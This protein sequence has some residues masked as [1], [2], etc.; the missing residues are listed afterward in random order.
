[1]IRSAIF[2]ILVLS[3]TA[4][5]GQPDK[6]WTW[7]FWPGSAVTEQGITD[8]LLSFKKSGFGGV[9][10]NAIYAARDAQHPPIPYM[11]N[12]W[13]EKI[14]Y[15]LKVADSLGMQADLSLVSGWPFGGPTVQPADAAKKLA[16]ISLGV[17][18]GG[19]RIEKKIFSPDTATLLALTACRSGGKP[20]QLLNQVDNHGVLYAR[21]PAG[22]WKLYG[23]YLKP[24]GQMVKRAGPGG[25]GRVMDPFNRQAVERYLSGFDQAA[26]TYS[27][28]KLRALFNDSYE[29][30]GA[31]GTP[32]ILKEFRIRR[33]YALEDYP[34][35]FLGPDSNP[36][37]LRILADY[38]ETIAELLLENFLQPWNEWC[39]AHGLLTRE[40][41]HG[42]PGNLL[43]LYAA[44]DIPE[45]ESFGSGAFDIPLVR[46][47]PDFSPATFGRPDPLV[48]KFASSAANLSGKK[49]VSAE[50]ATWLAN[51]FKVSLSQV[52]PQLD[53]L[54]AAGINQVMLASAAYSPPGV[55][56][57][58]WLFYAST[59]FGASSAFYS[60]LPDFSRYISTCQQL[61]QK[62]PT[63]NDLLL[64]FP[65]H[66]IISTIGKD[67]GNLV[68][69]DVH[70]PE[71][72]VYPF[73][74]GKLARQLME[75]GVS[76]DYVSD[77]QL[78]NLNP[79]DK[80]PILIPDCRVMPPE[81][82]SMLIKLSKRGHKIIF[83]N[84]LPSEVPGFRQS[85]RSVLAGLRAT[86]N[87]EPDTPNPKSIT[88]T[89]DIAE[90]LKNLGV[91]FEDLGRNGLRYIRKKNGPETLY[92]ITNLGNRFTEGWIKPGISGKS[93]VRLDP[94]T[95]Q[96]GR[97]EPD[98]E[99]RIFLQLSPGTSCFI[100]ITDSENLSIP[101][102]HNSTA[103]RKSGYVLPGP[104]KLT[105]SGGG[106]ATP[107][108]A[109]VTVPG[110]WTDLPDTLCRA[111]SG[112]GTY[113]TDFTLPKQIIDG[114]TFRL[115]LGDVREAAE[116]WV[117]DQ[118][119]G[120]VWCVPWQV[121]IPH[122][123]LREGSNHL[124]IAVTNHAANRIAWMDR[125]KIP[126][127]NFFFVDILYKD[128]NASG[129]EP[130]ESGLLGQ[131]RLETEGLKD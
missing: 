27:G 103:T 51:H 84:R 59:D 88:V 45:T 106:P 60:F 38:R 54:F 24:T 75:A 120:R 80:R 40:Q 124:K 22:E 1:M 35:I 107:A 11:S 39:H 74:Y 85:G 28:L 52:K 58:G 15:A 81:T 16:G 41:A 121:T 31:D 100:R 46:T 113:E 87:P 76:F 8:Q 95:Q 93:I 97:M 79:G 66:E 104:W 64:Y 126:W 20:V 10:I 48:M 92:F 50:S 70:H 131:V 78:Q 49:L 36:D 5:Y 73:D 25:E 34:D 12:E 65:F 29:V 55:P 102:W 47:D 122:G 9:S 91:K 33:G 108:P 127:K 2:L 37:K 7:W 63:D 112:T 105:F 72:W 116:V 119:L 4:G 110:S 109:M 90:T 42:A 101:V 98:S 32:D 128:F 23:L 61:L 86:P 67:M 69:L 30:Y 68:M 82:V 114:T 44:A 13:R 6:P 117:N 53:E 18:A 94:F 115:Q 89:S 96:T 77:R 43:D 118:P 130:V 62:A 3:A 19:N 56:W 129:W 26:G 123:I 71:K 83:H 111:F 57:P 125:N 17:I 21:L 99:G 14:G